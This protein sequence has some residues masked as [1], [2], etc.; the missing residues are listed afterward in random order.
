MADKRDRILEL[1]KY[2]ESLGVQVNLGKN[3]ARG[4]K[5]IF[6]SRE[7][8][9]RI[10][11]S[12]NIT[13]ASVLSTLLHEFAHFIHYK[14]D[15][16]LKSLEF[17]FED[18]SEE[19]YEELLSVTVKN[20]PKD[21]ASSLYETKKQL[22]E[23]NKILVEKIKSIYPDFKISEPCRKIERTLMYAFSLT[24]MQRDYIKLKS[25]QK[26]ISRINARINK[27]NKYY[28]QPSELWARFFELFF[29]DKVSALKLA[30]NVCQRL[31]DTRLS[32]VKEI[33]RIIF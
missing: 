31:E 9:F 7:D 13:E 26:N 21:F 11:I 14:Y 10:D 15:K 17:V 28:N 29:T 33:K 24:E 23:E 22:G 5:G 25:N 1:T 32:E 18:L 4:T 30:P 12:K 2:I 16:T 3:K 27:L 8:A 19:E 6:L 20:I